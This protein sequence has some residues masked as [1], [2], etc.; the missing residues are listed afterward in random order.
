MQKNADDN[1]TTFTVGHCKNVLNKRKLE[2]RKHRN[3]VLVNYF[4]ALVDT[5]SKW[6]VG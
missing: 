6:Y 2:R 1:L 5:R 4:K 3:N